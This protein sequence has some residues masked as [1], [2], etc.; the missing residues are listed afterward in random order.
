MKV[1]AN[2]WV[3]NGDGWHKPGDVFDVESLDGLSGAVAVEEKHAETK[4]VESEEHPVSAEAPEKKP[5]RRTR[6]QK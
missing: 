2:H 6:K 4:P 1:K 3:K 5:A